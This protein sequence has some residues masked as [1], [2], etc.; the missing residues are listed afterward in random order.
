MEIKKALGIHLPEVPPKAESEAKSK[1]RK[2]LSPQRD[3]FENISIANQRFGRNSYFSGKLLTVDSLTK[4]QNYTHGKFTF[5]LF[6]RFSSV[7]LQQGR[8]QTDNDWNESAGNKDY[9]KESAPHVH[10]DDD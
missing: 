3:Q 8:V 6:K 5:D 7:H 9:L 1:T 4:E 10:R 2:A